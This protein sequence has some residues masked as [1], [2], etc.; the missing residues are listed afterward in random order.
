VARIH[1]RVVLAAWALTL[2]ALGPAFLLAFLRPPA[3][4]SFSGAFA[5]GDDVAQ[6]L[7]FVEQASRGA[8]LFQNKFDARPQEGFV[9][10]P[11]WWAGG[12][13]ARLCGGS[14]D[15]GFLL[16]GALGILLL[17]A[18]AS[19]V[20]V[21]GGVTGPRAGWGLAVFTL[22]GGLGWLPILARFDGPYPGDVSMCLYPFR[23]MTVAAHGVLGTALLLWAT[24]SYT[25][26][27]RGTGSRSSW[28]PAAA[29]LA[30]SRPFDVALFAAAVGALELRALVVGEERRAVLAR[31]AEMLWLA[32]IAFYLLLAYRIHPSFAVYSHQNVVPLP[33]LSVFVWALA[34]VLLLIAASARRLREAGDVAYAMLALAL[35]P[36]LLLVF[37]PVPYSLQFASS[38]G[39][40]LLL[41]AALALPARILPWATAFLCPT[42]LMLLLSIYNPSPLAFMPRDYTAAALH[43]AREC[44]PGDVVYGPIEPSLAVAARSPCSVSIGHRVLTPDFARR[45]RETEVFY[46]PRT[47]SGWRESLL[48]ALGARF[49]MLPPRADHWLSRGGW[50]PVLRLPS[51]V[52]WQRT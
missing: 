19:R 14:T 35:F 23:H 21:L 47:L 7:S 11:S 1:W 15:A 46:D 28:L 30:L 4:S 22:G 20:L 40:A 33:E 50:R 39:A 25:G 17:L 43:L 10:N 32:P 38:I 34:P 49:V 2:A 41:L 51:F 12:V 36:L 44:R 13:L 3:G 27:R 9:V 29:I 37:Q 6:Y 48:A 31:A 24:A 45:A 16:L 5:F 8:V 42:S 18:A 26:W 52:L